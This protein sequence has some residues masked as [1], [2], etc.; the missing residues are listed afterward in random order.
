[1]TVKAIGVISRFILLLIVW[2]LFATDGLAADRGAAVDAYLR[3]LSRQGGFSGAAL[4]ARDGKVL[5]S[6][7]YGPANREWDIPNTPRTRF[8]IGSITKQFTAA[9]ILLLQERGKL[10]VSDPLGNYLEDCPQTWRDVTIHHL[11]SHTSGIPDRALP[12]D[13][14]PAGFPPTLDG[15]AARYVNT[16]LLFPA[17]ENWAYS[18]AG[19]ILLGYLIEKVSGQR[20][21]QFLRENIFEPLKMKN[22]GYD[23]SRQPVPRRAAGY[24][25]TGITV[26]NAPYTDTNIAHAAGALYSTVEDLYRWEQALFGGKLLSPASL[27]VMTTTI[28]GGYGYGQFIGKQFDR[29]V[30]SHE[31]RTSGFAGYL[32][33]FTNE[34]VTIVLLLNYDIG[35]AAL[36]KLSNDVA[37]ICF[38]EKCLVLHNIIAKI[39]LNL[40]DTYAGSYGLSPDYIITV[41]RDGSRLLARADGKPPVELFPTSATD[42]FLKGVDT[43]LTFVKDAA[44]LVTGL[45]LYQNGDH[46]AA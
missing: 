34:R 9:A 30:I 21:E 15:M 32:G 19:Y 14:P 23:D 38:G 16:P 26:I 25:C 44:G 40:Y 20:Y 12:L 1:L 4:V 3:T 42:F 45:I 17:G 46:T 31:G 5:L 36:D 24:I 13:T 37:A 10:S 41:I 18:N 8:R 43:K 35:L 27:Q 29:T 7:G 28:A 22:T 6:K 2:L 33:Y 11:L 39:D